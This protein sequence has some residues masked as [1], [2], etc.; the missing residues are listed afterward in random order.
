MPTNGL[1]KKAY[2]RRPTKDGVPESRWV[3]AAHSFA[4]NV[5]F[6]FP[7]ASTSESLMR[8]HLLQ[9]TKPRH[10]DVDVRARLNCGTS[11]RHSRQL[12]FRSSLRCGILRDPNS[13]LWKHP[14]SSPIWT[15]WR[16]RTIYSGS[17]S[18]QEVGHQTSLSHSYT[19][20]PYSPILSAA[21]TFS[22]SG[23][24]SMRTEEGQPSCR[25]V[26]GSR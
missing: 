19:H 12:R 2:E 6:V 18:R 24:P 17:P 20:R 15:S 26:V 4:A 9:N 21:A 10:N 23:M 7:P 25:S 22:M 3:Y 1:R 14:R 16:M 11:R 13:R 8:L 5:S